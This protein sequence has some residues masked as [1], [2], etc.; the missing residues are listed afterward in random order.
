MLESKI[1]DMEEQ[2]IPEE[3]HHLLMSWFFC[4][5]DDDHDLAK[6]E[7]LS[8][9]MKEEFEE[10]VSTKKQIYPIVTFEDFV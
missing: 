3:G 5:I 9:K 6:E 8:I 4:K 7:E 2:L 1:T 10:K